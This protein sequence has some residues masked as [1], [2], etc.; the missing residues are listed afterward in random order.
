MPFTVHSTGEFQRKT[1][2]SLVLKKL[3]KKSAKQENSS[4]FMNDN[5]VER[6]NKGRKPDNNMSLRR[7][8]FMPRNLD[9]KCRSRIPSLDMS[10]LHC[11]WFY[12]D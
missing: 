6:K 3:T 12:V 4:L 8:E 2:S 11:G 10:S 1:Y 7:L 5:F 9:E